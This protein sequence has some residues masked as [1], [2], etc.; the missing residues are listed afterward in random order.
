MCAFCR[1][2]DKEIATLEVNRKTK[3]NKLAANSEE[4]SSKD[5]HNLCKRRRKPTGQWWLTSPSAEEAETPLPPK[6]S[7]QNSKKEPSTTAP[8]AQVKKDKANRKRNQKQPALASSGHTNQPKESK[9]TKKRKTEGKKQKETVEI[10]D[11]VEEKE[12]QFP[13]QDLN[14]EDSSPMVFTHRD[15]SINSGK[16]GSF[17]HIFLENKV[18]NTPCLGW[19]VNHYLSYC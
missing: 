9:Q 15:V 18:H 1:P 19:P 12:Q 16:V 7:K 17:L 6:K 4:R 2:I 5:D 11:T 14:Q 10:I 8:K 13:D 3:Q